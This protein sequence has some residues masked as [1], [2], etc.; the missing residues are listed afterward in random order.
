MKYI[1]LGMMLMTG[2]V[3]AANRE[4]ARQMTDQLNQYAVPSDSTTPDR[5]LL[6]RSNR[7]NVD[8]A[9]VT[10]DLAITRNATQVIFT[11]GENLALTRCTADFGTASV[12]GATIVV[13]TTH[14]PIRVLC[15]TT[16]GEDRA[17]YTTYKA[18]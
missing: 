15:S 7:T 6:Y 14:A 3:F 13:T 18:P 5:G 1:I 17:F 12:V 9:A 8:N 11:R 4:Y 2:S 16:D 10:V